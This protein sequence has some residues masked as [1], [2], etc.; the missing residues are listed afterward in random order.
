VAAG[1]ITVEIALDAADPE[2]DLCLVATSGHVHHHPAFAFFAGLPGRLALDATALQAWLAIGGGQMLWDGLAAG[3]GFKPLLA[4]HSGPSAGLWSRRALETPSGLRGARVAATGLTAIALRALGAE[5]ADVPAAAL[6][7]A[8]SDGSLDAA[9]WLGPLAAAAPDMQPL[10]DR[11]YGPGLTPAGTTLTLAVRSARWR[12]LSPA[13]QAILEVCAQAEHNSALAQAQAHT[14]IE[15]HAL[16]SV[17]RTTLPTA[18]ADALDRAARE[19]I[20]TVATTDPAA[21]RIAGSYRMFQSELAACHP[22]TA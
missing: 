18:L 9:E 20:D 16:Q 17:Q 22:A 21:G 5:P 13:E 14:L 2:A 10:A 7:A 8:L 19:A 11:L 1:R 3:Y 4:G 6:K 12:E 15:R